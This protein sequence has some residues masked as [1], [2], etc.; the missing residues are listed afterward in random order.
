MAELPPGIYRQAI[1]YTLPLF[2]AALVHPRALQEQSLFWSAL[3]AAFLTTQM[4]KR[5][6]LI[7]ASLL[8]GMPVIFPSFFFVVYGAVIGQAYSTELLYTPGQAH[9]YYLAS[10]AELLGFFVS[11]QL[12]LHPFV[13]FT[14]WIIA[15]SVA[16]TA[17]PPSFEAEDPYLAMKDLICGDKIRKPVNETVILDEHLNI[18]VIHDVRGVKETD[19]HIDGRDGMYIKLLNQEYRAYLLRN[20]E[21]EARDYNSFYKFI[22]GPIRDM[23]VPSWAFYTM[24]LLA[25]Y[26]SVFFLCALFQ[27]LS[28]EWPLLAV[29]FLYLNN[30]FWEWVV[31]FVG[32][33]CYGSIVTQM[34]LGYFIYCLMSML[35]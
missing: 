3:P 16:C 30:I 14:L 13:S 21:E 24:F 33:R 20:E 32:V 28:F 22:Y 31:F 34:A 8:C 27:V 11:C 5:A 7:L 35:R 19:A 2:I 1:S 10:K 12:E 15:I 23:P 18:E 4:P 17:E 26:R 9:L 25:E 29:L 6:A